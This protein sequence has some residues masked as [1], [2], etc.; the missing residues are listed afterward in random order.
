MPLILDYI[1]LKYFIG[2]AQSVSMQRLG[3]Q[4]QRATMEDMDEC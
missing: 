3:K 2:F 1:N 4:D